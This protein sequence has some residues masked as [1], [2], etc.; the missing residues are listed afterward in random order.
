MPTVWLVIQINYFRVI[1]T[2]S[3]IT[4]DPFNG[5]SNS[6]VGDSYSLTASWLVNPAFRL[7]GWIG[8]LGHLLHPSLKQLFLGV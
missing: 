5:N 4:N 8:Y 6:I 1:G 7:G 3:A 2:S